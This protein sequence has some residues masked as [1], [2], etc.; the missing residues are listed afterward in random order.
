MNKHR[1]PPKPRDLGLLLWTL[2]YRVPVEEKLTNRWIEAGR[3]RCRMSRERLA[4]L[5]EGAHARHWKR[6][7]ERRARRLSY[8]REH[9]EIPDGWTPPAPGEQ[10]R[11]KQVLAMQLYWKTRA[12]VRAKSR[13][14]PNAVAAKLTTAYRALSRI[15]SKARRQ[16]ALDA[17]EARL[18]EQVLADSPSVSFREWLEIQGLKTYSEKEYQRASRGRKGTKRSSKPSSHGTR[19]GRDGKE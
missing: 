16:A 8:F 7:H 2:L 18:Y 10:D 4:S 19:S 9:G 6:L 5:R 17:L 11:S 13:K 3:Q 14:R 1:Q 15:R 12:K